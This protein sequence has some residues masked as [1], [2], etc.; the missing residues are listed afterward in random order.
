MKKLRK[1]STFFSAI[2]VIA[3]FVFTVSMQ[4]YPV[5]TSKIVGYRFYTVLTNSMEPV[6]PTYSLVFSKMIDE[7]DPIEPGDIITFQANRF[8]TEALFTHY[9]KETMPCDTME[10][11]CYRTQGAT[12]PIYDNYETVRSDI[13]GKYVFHIPYVGK[14]FLFM[15][16]KFGF[17]LYAELFI[18]WMVNKT[19]TTRWKEKELEEKQKKEELFIF[20]DMK[21]EHHGRYLLLSGTIENKTKKAVRY[22]AVKLTF[23]NHLHEVRSVDKWFVIGKEP[24]ASD[25]KKQFTYSMLDALDIEDYEIHVYKY[26]N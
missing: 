24:L 25:E 12:A 21:V 7:D 5:E 13:L 26:K 2:F 15:K 18:V 9:F 6:I 4:L 1:L 14:I 22:A 11:T 23:Y 16:S 19:I 8:G 10:D 3:L 20:S 17:L